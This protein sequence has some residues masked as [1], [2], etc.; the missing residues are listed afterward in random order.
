MQQIHYVKNDLL[1]CLKSKYIILFKI[2]YFTVFAILISNCKNTQVISSY[3]ILFN[4]HISLG[5]ITLDLN[6]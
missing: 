6:S 2:D 3:Y 1:L 5:K 4:I